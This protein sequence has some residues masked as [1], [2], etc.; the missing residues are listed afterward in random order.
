MDLE[1]LLDTI[2]FEDIRPYRDD[3][4]E[5]VLSRLGKSEWLV[6]GIRTAFLPHLPKFAKPLV[7]FALRSYMRRKFRSVKSVFDFQRKVSVDTFLTKFVVK[8]SISGISYSGGEFLDKKLSYLFITNHRDIVLDPALLN[9]VLTRYGMPLTQ[10]AFGDNLMINQTVADVIRINRSFIVKRNLPI[11]EQLVASLQLSAYIRHVLQDTDES[12]WI[13][14][15]PGRSKDGKDHTNAAVVKMLQ[16]VDRARKIPFEEF[17]RSCRI[18]PVA[19][20]YEYDPCDRMKAWELYHKKVRG[21]HKKGKYEDLVSMMAGMKGFKGRVHYAFSKPIEGTFKND[22]ELAEEIDRKIQ[23]SYRLW[24]TNYLA[25]D[26]VKGSTLF[27]DRYDDHDREQLMK[28]FKHLPDEVREI[29]LETY[30]NPVV[31][32]MSYVES[33]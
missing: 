4:V 3:E 2:D 30:A 24:A 19:I 32:K 6:S 11:R 7:D 29:L 22:R 13:A 28:R 1:K 16:L 33:I 18:V 15:G 20:S 21:E 8:K 14:Q 12:I 26:M 25:Y 10:I 5:E 31:T 9:Y 17:T 23:S 27:S